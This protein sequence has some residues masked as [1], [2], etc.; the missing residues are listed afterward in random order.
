M[1]FLISLARKLPYSSRSWSW[2]WSWSWSRLS[3]AA[4]SGSA[5]GLGPGLH[6]PTTATL[7][8]PLIC[9]Q[10]A[11]LAER[12]EAQRRPKMVDVDVDSGCPGCGPI[13]RVMCLH[14]A[15][16]QANEKQPKN[17]RAVEGGQQRRG[18]CKE[19]PVR[20]LNIMTSTHTECAQNNNKNEK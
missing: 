8:R 12:N 10:A 16:A 18:L 6:L 7:S 2:N 5:L 17:K 15:K 13:W 11:C 20:M 19:A 9:Q 4:T 1:C 14:K 3:L